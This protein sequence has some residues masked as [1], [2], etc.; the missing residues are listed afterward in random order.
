MPEARVRRPVRRNNPPP[1]LDHAYWRSRAPEVAAL[2]SAALGFPVRFEADGDARK[3]LLLPVS[4]EDAPQFYAWHVQQ[5]KDP[6]ADDPIAA[7]VA[8]VRSWQRWKLDNP[9]PVRR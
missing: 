7:A 5:A 8:L 1:D 6:W 3:F 9:K 4:P 2:A